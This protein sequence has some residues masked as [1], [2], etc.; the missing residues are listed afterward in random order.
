MILVAVGT[1]IHGFDELV[2]AAD[3]AAAALD[4]EGFAQIGH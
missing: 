3:R 2:A 4:L 1:F